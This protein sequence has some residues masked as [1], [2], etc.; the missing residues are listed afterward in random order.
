MAK[1]YYHVLG[2]DRKADEKTIKSAYR[3]LARKY[4][5]DVNP[6][7][8]A[9]ENRF[10]EVQEAYDVVGDADKRKLY[11]QYGDHWETAQ[12][13]GGIPGAGTAG[14]FQDFEF[15]GGG[16]GDFESIFQQIFGGMGGARGARTYT[17]GVEDPQ[18]AA[19]HREEMKTAQPRDLEKT[20][21][22]SL[23]EIDSG[24]KRKLVYQTMDAVQTPDGRVTTLP[25]QREV[26]VTVP[27]GIQEGKKLRIAGM[28]SSGLRGRAG[29][30]Y[31]VIQ[32]AKHPEFQVVGDHLEVDVNVPYP[33]AALGGEI[34]VPT[35]RKPLKMRIPAGT[36]SG[37]SFRLAGQGI[38]RMAGGRSDLMAR[39]KITVPKS[40]G[41]E[42]KRL[43]E[44][45][46]R[47]TEAKAER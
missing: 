30:L 18:A 7:D 20:I 35:L 9:A 13:F 12:K 36:Q 28:G 14:G 46:A 26:V 21:E 10:K 27:A 37:Q 42:E 6:N 5:P 15:V 38:A 23:E 29:D 47:L 41:A 39:V 3:K 19:R 43:L 22:V 34:K 31:V 16:G 2:V 24:T 8:K 17:Y 45:I 33:V 11:D 4:H 1:D 40:L 32:W 25:K 44:Q